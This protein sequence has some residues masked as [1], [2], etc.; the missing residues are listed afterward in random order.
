[1]LGIKDKYEKFCLDEAA[2]YVYS[3][4]SQPKEQDGNE[5]LKKIAKKK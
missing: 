4:I 1:M 5:V 3:K 2:C